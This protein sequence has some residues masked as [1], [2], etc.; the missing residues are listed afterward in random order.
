MKNA[1]Y[2]LLVLSTVMSCKPKETNSKEKLPDAKAF[3]YLQLVGKLG[4]SPM[5]MNLIQD[6]D[7]DGNP[8]Y[9]GSYTIDETQEPISI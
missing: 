9:N 2:C 3:G 5:H 6:Q 1:I 7:Y 4:D 8:W